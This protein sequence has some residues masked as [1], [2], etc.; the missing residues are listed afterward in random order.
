MLIPWLEELQNNNSISKE[1]KQAIYNDCSDL[2]EMAV[3]TASVDDMSEEERAYTRDAMRLAASG[4]LLGAAKERKET[5]IKNQMAAAMNMQMAER[6]TEQAKY[7]KEEAEAL[8]EQ[9]RLIGEGEKYKTK[10][11]ALDFVHKGM[12]IMMG[13]ATQMAEKFTR[14][15]RIGYS[16]HQTNKFLEKTIPEEHIPK[17]KA[18]FEEI[19][20]YAPAL[21]Q[22]PLAVQSIVSRTL[23]SGLTR[24]DKDN[25]RS[26][27][28]GEGYS[29]WD[30]AQTR[31]A[32]LKGREW[33]MKSNLRKALQKSAAARADHL[34]TI[35]ELIGEATGHNKVAAAGPLDPTKEYTWKKLD[36][37]QKQIGDLSKMQ[38]QIG[39]LSKEVKTVIKKVPAGSTI[40]QGT[41]PG[42]G[43]VTLQALKTLGLVSMVPLVAGGLTGIGKTLIDYKQKKKVEKD[44]EAS[45]NHAIGGR[46]EY[47][48]GL[49]E[50]KDKARSAFESLVH[51]APDVATQP[52][53]A[54]A[55][56]HKMVTIGG[57]EVGLTTG[58][59]K[60]LADIQKNIAAG[61]A[62][63]PFVSGFSSASKMTGLSN[64]TA[65]TMK[66]TS[67]PFIDQSKEMATAHL[68]E[69]GPG[70][71]TA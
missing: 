22:D 32:L 12:N 46:D 57:P 63:H 45:F 3:K 69:G 14:P 71:I 40:A 59:I 38:K 23:H 27:Q 24:E 48:R 42:L 5:A 52:G 8:K 49:R 53:A 58:D 64:I 35:F 43:K 61:R 4:N 41:K 56:M 18:R 65:E 25:L 13:P 70:F 30:T 7:R 50:N 15:T 2:I 19:L 31:N 55:F 11:K 21:A 67:Q 68:S 44:L 66:G 47:S 6:H 33:N 37:M 17:A 54:K 28:A 20:D 51:F 26:I 62:D 60:D 29:V 9:A 16:A 39:D 1:A 36:K 34:A 10:G